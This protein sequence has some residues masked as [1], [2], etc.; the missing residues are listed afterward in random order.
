MMTSNLTPTPTMLMQQSKTEEHHE[1]PFY[2]SILTAA[3][4]LQAISAYT[5]E[6]HDDVNKYFTEDLGFPMMEA[7]NKMTPKLTSCFT[8][9]GS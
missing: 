6:D 4:G 7:M 8:V 5:Q 1:D 3:L 2:F 9:C